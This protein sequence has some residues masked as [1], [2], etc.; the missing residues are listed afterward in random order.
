SKNG[1]EVMR[2]LSELNAEGTTIIMVTHSQHDASFA[3]RVINLFDG[4]IVDSVNEVL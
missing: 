3:H 4:Q 1:A 2:L